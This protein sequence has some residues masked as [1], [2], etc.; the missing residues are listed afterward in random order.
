MVKEKQQRISFFFCFLLFVF[1]FVLLCIGKGIMFDTIRYE[2]SSDVFKAAIGGIGALGVVT[3]VT[4]RLEPK[5]RIKRVTSYVDR[6]VAEAGT[7]HALL[8]LFF[9][10]LTYV[11]LEVKNLIAKHDHVGFF[12]II[13]KHAI[14]CFLYP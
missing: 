6:S 13:S 8:S 3:E 11:C 9:S 4:F 10:Y 1:C 2:P 14:S 5:F 7:Q 12:C